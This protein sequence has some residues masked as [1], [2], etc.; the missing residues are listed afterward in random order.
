[1]PVE[2]ARVLVWIRDEHSN[3]FGGKVVSLTTLWHQRFLARTDATRRALPRVIIA[4]LDV[5]SFRRSDCRVVSAGGVIVAIN[6][7]IAGSSLSG[8][9]GSD[10]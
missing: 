9:G 3:W 6:A 2:H 5:S 4:R 1:V 10:G 8:I 7:F